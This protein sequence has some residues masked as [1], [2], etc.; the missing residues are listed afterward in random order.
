MKI[1]SF[2]VGIKN[3]AYSYTSH[4]DK[5]TTNILDW[6]IINL[7]DCN[8]VKC[9]H[10]ECTK[11]IK[12]VKN[13]VYTCKKHSS[14]PH[15]II[16]DTRAES[17]SRMVRRMNSRPTPSNIS[18]TTSGSTSTPAS[19]PTQTTTPSPSPSYTPPSTGY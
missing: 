12:Y 9:Y 3:L 14:S 8:N 10:P 1:L 17:L 13:N 19:T 15:S 2:D 6:G 5:N 7:N 16:Y 18:T 11:P 4:I